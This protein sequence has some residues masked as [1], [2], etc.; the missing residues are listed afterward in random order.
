MKNGTGKNTNKFQESLFGSSIVKIA[1]LEVV[2]KFKKLIK[3]TKNSRK[4]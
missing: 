4:T 1:H 2:K 3:V